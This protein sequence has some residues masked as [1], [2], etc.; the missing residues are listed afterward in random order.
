M[1]DPTNIFA[2]DDLKFLT[3]YSIEVFE[4]SEES[5]KWAID[6]IYDQSAS[7][8]DALSEHG[9]IRRIR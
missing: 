8:D 4:T 9:G 3:G 5:L 1:T 7:L 6:T 2:V